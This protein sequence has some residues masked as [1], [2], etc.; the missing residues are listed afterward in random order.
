MHKR[1]KIWSLPVG[2]PANKVAHLW[3]FPLFFTDK[4]KIEILER[5]IFKHL[6]KLYDLIGP[7]PD[8][9][10]ETRYEYAKH[11]N[12]R[13]MLEAL[14]GWFIVEALG[15]DM[16]AMSPTAFLKA[17]PIPEAD[18]QKD[19]IELVYN[20]LYDINSK[21][22]AYCYDVHVHWQC[23]AGDQLKGWSNLPKKNMMDWQEFQLDPEQQQM[24][25]LPSINWVRVKLR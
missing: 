10:H 23:R 17:N 13:A 2:H 22:R 15:W 5:P 7:S 20:N 4:S 1:A 12:G 8:Y 18:N 11:V 6:L 24:L 25:H 19:A 9:T 21:W 3:V 14:M 16:N